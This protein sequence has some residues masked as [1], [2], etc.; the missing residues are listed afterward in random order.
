MGKQFPLAR[1][2]L[3]HGKMGSTR[4]KNSF[5][6]LGGSYSKNNRCPLD[7]KSI[8]KTQTEAN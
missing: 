6:S 2:K 4:Y 8:P 3:F 5:R 7:G 1:M